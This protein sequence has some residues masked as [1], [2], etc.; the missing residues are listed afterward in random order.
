MSAPDADVAS[1]VASEAT[2]YLEAIDLFRSLRLDVTCR[3]EAEELAAPRFAELWCECRC[4][5]CA[6]A[7]VRINGHHVCVSVQ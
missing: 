6:S 1:T 7:H 5:R 4:D 3:C 2:R